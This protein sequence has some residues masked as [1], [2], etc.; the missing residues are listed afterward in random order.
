MSPNPNGFTVKLL[1][2]PDEVVETLMLACDPYTALAMTQTCR[3]LDDRFNNELFWKT[4]SQPMRCRYLLPGQD[5]DEIKEETY[6]EYVIAR[7]KPL[8]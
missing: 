1:D 6:L 5:P 2:L 8:S 4:Y 7:A 3:Y